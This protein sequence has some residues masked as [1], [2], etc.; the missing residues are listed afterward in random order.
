[1]EAD[2]SE[3]A[4]RGRPIPKSIPQRWRLQTSS[5]ITGVS[6]KH[7]GGHWRWLGQFRTLLQPSKASPAA[8]LPRHIEI[9]RTWDG[10]LSIDQ[11][12][13]DGPALTGVGRVGVTGLEW[14]RED[15]L[16]GQLI[17]K[18]HEMWYAPA[19][20]KVR[21]SV[22]FNIRICSL[23][24]FYGPIAWT[25]WNS[26][27]VFME[28]PWLFFEIMHTLELNTIVSWIP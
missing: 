24:G 26:W 10:I 23:G 5:A 9:W 1:M 19:R 16:R 22:K 3:L 21:C 20:C 6:I 4:E 28:R 14:T 18:S 17:L 2:D 13:D 12:L 11:A 7:T 27:P 15:C 25:M 8:S